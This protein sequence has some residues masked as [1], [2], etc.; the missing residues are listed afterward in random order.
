MWM[1]CW[2]GR[3]K[4]LWK[5][6]WKGRVCGCSDLNLARLTWLAVLVGLIFCWIVLQYIVSYSGKKTSIR[7]RTLCTF[8]I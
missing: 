2:M 7:G 1:G 6:G 5:R 4:G 3:L 8:W